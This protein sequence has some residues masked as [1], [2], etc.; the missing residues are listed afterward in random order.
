M[1][2][3][4]ATAARVSAMA[5]EVGKRL[6]ESVALVHQTASPEEFERYRSAIA[7]IMGNLL[8]EIMNP[9]YE[10]HPTLRPAEL[11]L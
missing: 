3:N 6:D 11:E 7:G 1:L 10:Q 9:I 2:S 8:L 4:R 5:L